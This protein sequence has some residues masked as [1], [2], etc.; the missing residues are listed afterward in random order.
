LMTAALFISC[1]AKSRG[2]IASKIRAGSFLRM[3][4]LLAMGAM[5]SQRE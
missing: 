1:C 5:R 2:E 4:G 3:Q